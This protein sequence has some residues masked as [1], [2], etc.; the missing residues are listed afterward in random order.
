MNILVTGSNGQLGTEFQKIAANS[1]AYNWIFTDV[2]ELDICSKADVDSFF[3][4]KDIN[5]CINCAAYTAVDKAED[6]EEKAFAINA[7]AVGNLAQACADNHALLLHVS[8][9]YVFDGNGTRPYSESDP[10]NPVS[11]YGRT[12]A[13]GEKFVFDSG[14]RYC[15]IRTAWLYSSTGN[16][17]VKTMLRLGNEKESITVVN[18]QI[19]SPTWAHDL[20]TYIMLLIDR[21][22]NRN[23]GEIFHFSNEGVISWYDFASE[24]MRLGN[25]KCKVN[26]ISSKDYPSKVKRPPYSVLSKDKISKYTGTQVPNWQPSLS[27][28]IDELREKGLA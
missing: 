15:I 18:D 16:N 2:A 19:G 10:I 14:C 27:K 1:T 25:R 23:I 11:A 20:A 24:I 6:E 13:S 22:S 17:F 3:K 7:A 9:D 21:N 5:I 8:T 12:K 28:C 4:A 26:P